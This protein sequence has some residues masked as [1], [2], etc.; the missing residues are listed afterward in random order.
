MPMGVH[1]FGFKYCMQQVWGDFLS[2]NNVCTWILMGQVC[3]CMSVCVCVC[4]CTFC[5]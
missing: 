4:L 1:V 3:K 2:M 5:V